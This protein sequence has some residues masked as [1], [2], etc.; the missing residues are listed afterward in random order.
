[1][2]TNRSWSHET[3]FFRDLQNFWMSKSLFTFIIQASWCF[4]L[5]IQN[6]LGCIHTRNCKWVHLTFLSRN[7][8]RFHAFFHGSLRVVSTTSRP[9]SSTALCAL[10]DGQACITGARWKFQQPHLLLTAYESAWKVDDSQGWLK[11]CSN[12]QITNAECPKQTICINNHN[13][14]ET[15]RS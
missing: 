3:H 12:D 1:M 7:M 14:V 11:F 10:R 2:T 5:K 8:D 9:G 4:Y 15:R 6:L 13:S